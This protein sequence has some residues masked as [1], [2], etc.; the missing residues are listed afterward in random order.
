MTENLEIKWLHDVVALEKFRS[1]T[2]AAERRYISQSSFSRRIRALESAVGFEIFDRGSNPLQLTIQGKSFIVYARNLLD[3]M[4]FQINRIK[5]IDL[6]SQRINVA[7]AHSLSTYLLPDFIGGFSKMPKKVFFVE[8]INVDEAV[9]NLKEGRSDFILSF[10]NE[11]LMTAPFMH[12]QVLE[13]NL[14][15][16]SPCSADGT[17]FFQLGDAN[18]P[19]MKYTDESYMGRQVNQLLD[20]KA[21]DIPLQVSFI[22][23]MSG[24][25]KQM[26]LKGNGIGWL[27]DYST[28]H[29]IK[30]GKLAILDPK[31]SI[32]VV[33]YIYRVRSRL[34]LSAER[35]WQYMTTENTELS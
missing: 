1:F 25:L 23:S 19:F 35:F 27:P 3:D 13:T 32:K 6:S 7:A 24:L 34:N 4:N 18:L 10:Y 33:V 11:E 30:T 29:E 8:S 31:L 20:R 14:N 21:G 26:V 2:E 15:L 17:P 5:G 22:S 12:H 28:K 16:V 9:F